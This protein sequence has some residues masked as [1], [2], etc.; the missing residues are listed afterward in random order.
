MKIGPV[1]A[2]LFHAEGQADRQTGGRIGMT[3]PMVA[4]RNLANAPNNT[5][6]SRTVLLIK[7]ISAHRKADFLQFIF[8]HASAK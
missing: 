8:S 2:E 3:K 4:F 7:Q 5:A 6:N 1:G